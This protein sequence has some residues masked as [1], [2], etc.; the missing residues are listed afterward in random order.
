MKSNIRKT[1]KCVIWTRVSTAKQEKNGGSLD[2]QRQLSEQYAREQNLQIVGYYGGTHESAKVPG[3]L[4]KEMIKSVKKD[5][6]VGKIICSEFDRFSR[7]ASQA[8]G[9]IRELYDL[10]VPVCSVK[11][12]FQTDTKDNIMIASNLLLMA[13]WDNDK[14]ADKFYS[15]R[16]HCYESGAYTGVLP[17]GY[18]R[19][20]PKTGLQTK[21]LNSYCFLD[22][23][24]KKIKC[25]FRW[26]LQG[27]LNSQILDM[28]S[29]IGLNITKQTLNHIFNNPFY[30][31]KIKSKMLD[32]G[33]KDGKIEKA[34]S[35][36]DWLKVQKIMSDRSGKYTHKKKVENAPLKGYVLCSCCGKPLTAYKQKGYWY[37][38][39][40]TKGCKFN[41]S[42][43]KLH[44]KYQD[45]LKSFDVPKE[46]CAMYED[47]IG[48]MMK[49]CNEEQLNQARLLKKEKTEI[50]KKIN[51]C[52]TRYAL[53]EIES[54]IYTAAV[55]GFEEKLKVI[56]RE[57]GQHQN[58]LSNY[59]KR[60]DDILLMCSN[61]S[62]WWHNADL[63]TKKRLQ[64]LV[65]PHGIFYD[66]EKGD[67]RTSDR[68]VVFDIIDKLSESY[69]QKNEGNS[70]ENP[71]LVKL[72]AG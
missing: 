19:K 38:K 32:E 3:A 30:A 53:G 48:K 25:A 57:L 70:F 29:K 40:N 36:E 49:V 16:K 47:M 4:F 10:G 46:L 52:K 17:I 35:Y 56:D 60:L 68:N 59:E 63:E 58:I 61:T 28:L 8:I 20:D 1:K 50:E 15:G 64:K 51:T 9:I 13:T 27:Y 18:T 45:I 44:N 24:G 66:R 39:C 23:N 22:E 71:S 42:A 67:Y 37:Y 33:M 2:Y 31:G 69:K 41:M 5:L 62:S 65:F 26:K 21:S 72:C 12:G 7:D 43:N 55:N 14:R 54:D 11:Q 34:V 6:S